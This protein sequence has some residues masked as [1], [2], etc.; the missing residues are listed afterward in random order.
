MKS[1]VILIL[2]FLIII[3]TNSCVIK[4]TEYG[5]HMYFKANTIIMPSGYV[6]TKGKFKLKDAFQLKDTQMLSP[7]C[8]YM[9][10][11]GDS[12]DWLKFSEDGR[13]LYSIGHKVPQFPA[14]QFGAWGGYYQIQGNTIKIELTYTEK[15][16]IWGRHDIKG[17]I[18]GDTLKFY[19]GRLF[20]PDVRFVKDLPSHYYYKIAIPHLLNK[21][22]F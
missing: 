10:K 19:E 20:A 13:V 14:D 21:P 6:V 11:S 8:I 22:D 5:T 18:S 15:Y 16:N 3:L 1:F 17:T 9:R 2:S 12:T 4:K 7:N